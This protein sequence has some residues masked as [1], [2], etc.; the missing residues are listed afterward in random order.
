M[1]DAYCLHTMRDN[2][3]IRVLPACVKP[4]KAEC[5]DYTVGPDH[6]VTVCEGLVKKRKLQNIINIQQTS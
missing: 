3:R 1:A 2:G 4:E 6:T 5:E